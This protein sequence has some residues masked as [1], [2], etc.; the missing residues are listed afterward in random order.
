MTMTPQQLFE[1]AQL[2]ALALLDENE[3]VRF[4]AALANA[5]TALHDQVEAE[6][7]RFVDLRE[8]LPDVSPPPE[9]RGKVVQ[10]VLVAAE[11]DA[12]HAV[13]H[14]ADRHVRPLRFGTRVSAIWRGAAIGFAAA[15]LTLGLSTLYL[16]GEH[17]RL[18]DNFSDSALVQSVV[19][20]FGV[21][22]VQRALF[23]A[24]TQ[25][26]IFQPAASTSE[27]SAQASIWM[28][29]NWEESRLFCLELAGEKDTESF[30]VVVLNDD[31][32]VVTT[33]AEFRST[34]ALVSS[35]LPSDLAGADRLGIIRGDD[36]SRDPDVLLIA[37]TEDTFLRL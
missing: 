14:D 2:D 7:A 25:R 35:E 4:E 23:D 10:A 33:I 19:E 12:V 24:D 31:D 26:V 28:N 32:Q 17:E 34:G 37:E 36:T 9:L 3:R 29:P 18:E 16:W 11:A 27:R 13:R 5:P 1:M 8:F 6:R 21:E 22:Y 30:R 20:N 15:S